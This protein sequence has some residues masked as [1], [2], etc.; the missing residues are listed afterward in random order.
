MP[1]AEKAILAIAIALAS[2]LIHTLNKLLLHFR[3]QCRAQDTLHDDGVDADIV[4]CR[5]KRAA[6]GVK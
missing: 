1:A 5:H 6:I 4:A 2:L 3:R